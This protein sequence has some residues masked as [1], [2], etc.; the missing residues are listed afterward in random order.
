MVKTKM[1]MAFVLGIFFVGA[2][3]AES[4]NRT[5]QV[6]LLLKQCG[7][8]DRLQQFPKQVFREIG[9]E[10]GLTT[11]KEYR[12]A[13]EAFIQA[14]D[15]EQMEKDLIKKMGQEIN[16]RTTAIALEWFR[17]PLG[18]RIA[19]LE[20]TTYRAHAWQ[21]KQI[22][23]QGL[24]RNPPSVRR[25]SQIEQIVKSSYLSRLDEELEMITAIAL[26]ESMNAKLPPEERIDPD[27]ILHELQVQ[28]NDRK[29]VLKE[30]QIMNFLYLYHRLQDYEIEEYLAFLDSQDGKKFNA[31]ILSSL[32]GVFG[33]AGKNIGTALGRAL[34]GERQ[35]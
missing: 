21:E 1:V 27:Y 7:I 11:S 25:M 22:F 3:Y 8:L 20:K 4:T 33:N 31:A 2:S 24:V 13:Q 14:F 15:V 18:I 30:E 28:R 34:K 23:Q 17:S 35:I 26:T 32:K 29:Q 5:D 19:K 10:D 12:P 9:H 16:E 6:R